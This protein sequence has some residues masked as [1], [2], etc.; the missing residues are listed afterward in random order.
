VWFNDYKKQNKGWYPW[1]IIYSVGDAT[2]E[3]YTIQALHVNV[4]IDQSLLNPSGIDLA[5]EKTPEFTLD[6]ILDRAPEEI[7]NKPADKG[8]ADVDE[9][10]LKQIIKV[11]EEKYQ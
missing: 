3:T 11:F 4:P 7:Q 2:R 6:E 5:S 9:E 1:E 8:P 10:R